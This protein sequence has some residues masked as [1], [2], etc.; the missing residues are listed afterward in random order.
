MCSLI[1]AQNTSTHAMLD[2]LVGLDKANDTTEN[3]SILYHGIHQK[4]PEERLAKH[5]PPYHA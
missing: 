5:D 4:L 1:A 2:R 3:I